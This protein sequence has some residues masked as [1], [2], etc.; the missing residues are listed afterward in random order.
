MPR[1]KPRGVQLR[2]DA[3]EV[4]PLQWAYLAEEWRPGR[5]VPEGENPLEQFGWGKGSLRSI[6]EAWE[7]C[8]DLILPAWIGS[9]PGTRPWAWWAFDAPRWEDPW[10]GRFYH[11]TF[12]EPRQRVGGIG[13]PDFEALNIVP[14]FEA[15]VPVRFLTPPD[16]RAWP[17]LGNRIQ[18]RPAEAYDRNAPPTYE[19]QAAYLKRLGLL[20][21][22][23]EEALSEEDF[24]PVAMPTPSSSREAA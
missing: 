8:R 23:E 5:P 14:A 9:R 3:L 18:D 1:E 16:L 17:E 6:E 13:D 12:A 15:G 21:E 4:T 24:A 22:G 20:E 10:E 2:R 19:S 7:L 11:R